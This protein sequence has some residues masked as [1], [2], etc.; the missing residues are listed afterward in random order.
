MAFKTIKENGVVVRYECSEHGTLP[1]DSEHI[2]YEKSGNKYRCKLCKKEYAE[3]N[4]E[5]IRERLK[6]YRK[7]NKEVI[8]KRNKERYEK[9]K[10]KII[11]QKKE[12]RENNRGAIRERDKKYRENNKGAIRER[13]RKYCENNKEATR[14]YKKEYYKNNKERILQRHRGYERNKYAT[15]ALFRI[16]QLLRKGCYK[17]IKN[18]RT[19]EMLGLNY[20]GVI[21]HLGGEEKLLSD[22]YH[23]DHIYPLK[24]FTF[25]KSKTDSNHHKTVAC[26]WRNLQLLTCKE[27]LK[28]NDC[29]DHPTQTKAVLESFREIGFEVSVEDGK[30]VV[31]KC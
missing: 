16:I 21:R 3:K 30:M 25:D 9:N 1:V 31:R 12:Y 11:E 5:V 13:H 18:K 20:E 17:A 29:L 6:E 26:N 27:N 10:E 22:E 14:E 2:R 24:A 7:N 23:I 4:K 28:K 19:E 15:D 8:R